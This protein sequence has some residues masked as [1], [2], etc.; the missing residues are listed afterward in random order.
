MSRACKLLLINGM[1]DSIYP[2]ED[3]ILV[4]TQGTGK[5]FVARGDRRQMGNPGADEILY[6]WIGPAWFDPALTD[7]E[8][9]MVI[10]ASRA[11]GR[12]RHRQVPD[13]DPAIAGRSDARGS[14]R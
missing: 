7:R 12:R 8:R 10:I 13:P 3:S 14:S 1:E 5:D 9:S 2:I 4:A 6:E 11:P